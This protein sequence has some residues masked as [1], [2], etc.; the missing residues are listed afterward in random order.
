MSVFAVFEASGSFEKSEMQEFP[1]FQNLQFEKNTTFSKF[2][3]NLSFILATYVQRKSC[4]K[5]YKES[6]KKIRLES[7]NPWFRVLTFGG[8]ANI[9]PYVRIKRLS[10]FWFILK[11]LFLAVFQKKCEKFPPIYPLS[12]NSIYGK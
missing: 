10:N 2:S 7:E 1:N 5:L 3:Q 8:L 12:S 6:P 4:Y 11:T 9:D